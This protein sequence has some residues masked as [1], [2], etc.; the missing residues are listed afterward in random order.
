MLKA[1]SVPWS[2]DLH[3]LSALPFFWLWLLLLSTET[4]IP[5]TL[6]WC[7]SSG[8]DLVPTLTLIC[9]DCKLTQNPSTHLLAQVFQAS[10]PF[11]ATTT[12]PVFTQR[13]NLWQNWEVELRTEIYQKADFVLGTRL[14]PRSLHEKEVHSTCRWSPTLFSGF[15]KDWARAINDPEWDLKNNNYLFAF[16]Q[17]CYFS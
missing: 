10:E 4:L 1:S 8:T 17:C 2:K 7:S 9:T 6:V 11:S 15:S 16:L 5:A 14:S 3:F 12:Y 13:R